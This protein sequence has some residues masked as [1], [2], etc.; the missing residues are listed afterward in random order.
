MTETTLDVK[1]ADGVM[2][3]R[4]FRPDG[5]G[6]LPGGDLLDMD[7]LGVR[8]ALSEMAGQL[9]AGGY[10]VALPNL[11]YRAGAQASFDPLTVFSNPAE[12]TRIMGLIKEVT[13]PRVEADTTALFAALE[14]DPAADLRKVGTVGYCMGGGKAISAAGAFPDRVAAAASY[15]GGHL[16][17]DA[18]DSPHHL[19]AQARGRVY[20]GYAESRQQLSPEAQRAQLEQSLADARVAYD[21]ELYHAGHGFAV[22]DM[23]VYDAA[24]AARHW[25][26]LGA[27]FREALA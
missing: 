6:R 10:C 23:P 24:A 5:E 20:V 11:F 8:P 2:T 17:T 4:T 12:R 7:G 21:V 25:E 14:S 19:A 16:A 18:A 9:A 3:T 1:T 26:T 27:L 22:P 15:H 13:W